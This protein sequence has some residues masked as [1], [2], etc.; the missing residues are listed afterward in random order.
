MSPSKSLKHDSKPSGE[1][2][3]MQKLEEV[4]SSVKVENVHEILYCYLING[5]ED[6]K[7][8]EV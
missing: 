1:Q 6:E 5:I 2:L 7:K 8:Q 4:G 3:L